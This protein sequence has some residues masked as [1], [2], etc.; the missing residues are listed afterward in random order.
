SH[1]MNDLSQGLFFM[2]APQ[3]DGLREAIILPAEMVG[4]R[5]ENP[6]VVEE[7]L[8]HLATTTG[9]LPLLQFTASKLWMERDPAR[10]MLTEQSYRAIGGIAGALAGHADRVVGKLS[11][12]VQALAR[13]VFMRLVTPE[14]TRAIVSVDDLR[15]M[16]KDKNEMQSLLDHLVQARLL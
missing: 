14:K 3:R 13:A 10:R 12:N 1:F 11:P 5:F 9:A 8:D 2:S 16:T 4:Y 7:M 15:E 6:G